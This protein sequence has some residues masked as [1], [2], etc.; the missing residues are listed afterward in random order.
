MIRNHEIKI[1]F[2]L[3][4]NEFLNMVELVADNTNFKLKNW[5]IWQELNYHVHDQKFNIV[6]YFSKF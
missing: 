6:N 5:S 2:I 4:N 3:E 1:S